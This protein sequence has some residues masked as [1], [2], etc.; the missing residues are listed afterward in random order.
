M[1]FAFV[2]LVGCEV[3]VF[4][5]EFFGCFEVADPNGDVFDFHGWFGCTGAFLGANY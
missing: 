1:S 5:I 4:C 3:K 2:S